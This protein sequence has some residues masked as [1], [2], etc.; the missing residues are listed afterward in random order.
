M[1]LP[2]LAVTSQSFQLSAIVTPGCLVT[3]GS[4]GALGTLNFGSFSGADSRQVSASFV[5]NASLSLA[6]TPGVALSMS[7]DGGSYYATQRNMQRT[8]GSERVPYRLYSAA[9]L[10]AN[11]EIGINQPVSVSIGDSNAIALPIFGVA[12]LTGLSPAGNY[13]DRLTVTLS[14]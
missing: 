3:T 11:S 10:A 8:G 6:C 12:T 13:T 14:W 5:P 9:S 2:A 1:A 4:G 7:I